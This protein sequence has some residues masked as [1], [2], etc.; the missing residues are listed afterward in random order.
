MTERDKRRTQMDDLKT[1]YHVVDLV[2]Q[3]SDLRRGWDSL[4]SD[5]FSFF[6][7]AVAA[8]AVLLFGW[9]LHR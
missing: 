4:K 1:A 5:L 6:V 2:Q 9:W 8:G 3:A 7:H